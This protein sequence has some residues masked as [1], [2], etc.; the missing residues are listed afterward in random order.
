MKITISKVKT[1]LEGVNSRLDETEDFIN[2]MEHKL[3]ENAKSEQQKEKKNQIIEKSLRELWDNIRHNDIC[4]ITVP[5]GEEREEE[6]ENLS[7]EIMTEN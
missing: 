5:E 1:T 6:I 3:V 4:I 2:N 7:E